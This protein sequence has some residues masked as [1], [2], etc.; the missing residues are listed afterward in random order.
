MRWIQHHRAG[1][2][3]CVWE[4][5]YQLERAQREIASTLEISEK[6]LKKGSKVYLVGHLHT[7]K[8]TENSGVE[9]YTTDVVLPR[10][11]GHLKFKI[12]GWTE[13]F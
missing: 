5:L 3:N 9:D 2:E 6:Y 12:I 4:K 13:G 10:F 8:W 1:G 11:L 7:R